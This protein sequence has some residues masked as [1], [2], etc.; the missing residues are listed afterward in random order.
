MTKLRT[1]KERV[2]PV[3]TGYDFQGEPVY[4]FAK[5]MRDGDKPDLIPLPRDFDY[6]VVQVNIYCLKCQGF[7]NADACI[8]QHTHKR[9]SSKL[10][11]TTGPKG[12]K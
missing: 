2:F 12:K 8:K 9:P 7:I 10:R 5:L 6:Q 4:G 3:I 1:K 11:K